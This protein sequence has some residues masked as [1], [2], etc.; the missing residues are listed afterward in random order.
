MTDNGGF[1][2]FSVKTLELLNGIVH[3]NSKGWLEENRRVYE[4]AL[5]AP[6]KRLVAD[7]APVVGAIDPR[8]DIRPAVGRT[9]SRIYRDVRFSSDK[10]PLRPN[11]WITFKRPGSDGLHIPTFYFDLAFDHW[12]Y[13]MGF[14]SATP[15]W[16]RVFRQVI[17]SRPEPFVAALSGIGD[18]LVLE[19]ECYSRP[20]VK[21]LP[22]GF[23]PEH[24]EALS[25]FLDKKSF[26][27]ACRQDLGN[28]LFSKELARCLSE[29][30]R[31][32]GPVYR[33]LAGIEAP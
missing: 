21:S 17:L 12:S 13:G 14:Y 27:W 5:L 32:L 30:F 31:S 33:F 8:I 19:G 2:G 28:I 18:C 15:G 11:M 20:P 9:I 7:L 3:N 23:L 24:K 16:M 1:E 22:P 25:P 6:M 4:T 10:S 26:Y 29:G